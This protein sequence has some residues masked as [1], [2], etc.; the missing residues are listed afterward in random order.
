MELNV[1]RDYYDKKDYIYLKDTFTI[2]PNTVTVL[3]G[4]NGSGKST[5]LLV[6]KEYCRTHNIQCLSFN[7]IT[8]GGDYAR[9]ADAFHDDFI[10]LASKACSS[11]GE[12]LSMNLGK[13]LGT[14]GRTLRYANAGSKLVV[15]LDASDSGASLDRIDDLKSVLHECVIPDSV[16]RQAE[17]YIVVSAN[18]F[19]MCQ[20]EDCILV[21]TLEHTTY[22]TYDE[23]KKDILASR[24]HNE[25]R[26]EKIRKK[27]KK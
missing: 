10:T 18:D 19:E 23:Y 17:T 1:T 3:T 15:L 25:K 7:N 9:S 22:K 21:H 26:Y 16:S 8:D 6:I 27:K 11:E 24:K 20:D 5:L 2:E 4:C 12:E 14:V 13:F